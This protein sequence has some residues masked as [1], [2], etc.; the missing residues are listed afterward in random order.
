[1]NLCIPHVMGL[2]KPL[3][4]FYKIGFGIELTTKVY[5]PVNKETQPNQT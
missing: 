3:K 4:F 2:K 1:M 5:M